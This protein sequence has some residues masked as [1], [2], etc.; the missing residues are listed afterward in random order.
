[1]SWNVI[2]NTVS[3][4]LFSNCS[5]KRCIWGLDKPNEFAQ[6]ELAWKKFDEA[7]YQHVNSA[8]FRERRVQPSSFVLRF[9]PLYICNWSD[10]VKLCCV[11]T[12]HSVLCYM[13]S[14][15]L[16]VAY[17][18]YCNANLPRLIQCIFLYF[19]T[20]ETTIFCCNPSSSSFERRPLS[21][22]T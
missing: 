15:L 8:T 12:G 16:N 20:L 19:S 6:G 3:V 4:F 5:K 13:L 17:H 10:V 9:I 18:N 2:G 7:A 14:V 11:Y 1:M 21:S 22:D